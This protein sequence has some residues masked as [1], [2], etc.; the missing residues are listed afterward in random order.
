MHVSGLQKRHRLLKQA[1][2][3]SLASE[4]APDCMTNKN[5]HSLVAPMQVTARHPFPLNG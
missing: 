2:L 4:N 3:V 1:V 5:K